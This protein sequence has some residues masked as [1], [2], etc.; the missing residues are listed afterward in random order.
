MAR[1]LR[2]QRLSPA[3]RPLI[4]CP[5]NLGKT[6]LRPRR[7]AVGPCSPPASYGY[8]D[9]QRTLYNRPTCK[10]FHLP[11]VRSAYPRPGRPVHRGATLIFGQ[12]P[13]SVPDNLV[14]PWIR[15]RRRK[16]GRFAV[17]DLVP[18]QTTLRRRRATLFCRKQLYAAVKQ[19]CL[20]PNNLASPWI[21]LCCREQPCFVVN[22]LASPW[23]TLRRL[24]QPSVA[25]GAPSARLPTA[26]YPR[27][28]RTKQYQIIFMPV[29]KG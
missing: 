24:Q 3:F 18:L 9:C 5:R 8:I 17:D 1:R 22:N 15:L 20:A 4:R 14:P 25:L 11:A 27:F 6:H 21:S 7:G 23:I 12:Q 19:P 29:Q 10:I 28:F 16:Q 2:T 13:C 26:G